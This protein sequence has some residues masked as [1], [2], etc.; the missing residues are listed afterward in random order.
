MSRRLNDRPVRSMR[1]VFDIDRGI[2]V[3]GDFA[4]AAGSK[5]RARGNRSCRARKFQQSYQMEAR[6]RSRSAYEGNQDWPKS[7]S[8]L[9][10]TEPGISR[11]IVLPASRLRLDTRIRFRT[12]PSLQSPPHLAH[13][14]QPMDADSSAPCKH[15]LSI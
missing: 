13:V 9:Q 7:G 8:M 2:W 4:Y 14:I 15:W 1:W 5:L 12:L 6:I 11:G 3:H 10:N